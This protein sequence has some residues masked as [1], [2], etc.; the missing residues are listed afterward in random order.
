MSQ[1]NLLTII[2]SQ[3]K[4]LTNVMLRKV[5]ISPES[6]AEVVNQFHRLYHDSHI[7]GKTWGNTSWFGV[8][9]LK[10]PLDLWVYQEII[11]EVRPDIIIEC[12]TASGGS[13]LFL[14]NMCDMVGNGRVITVDIEGKPG[15]PQHP[16]TIYL[17]GSSTSPEIIREIQKL[18]HFGDKVMVV[19]DSDHSRDHVLKELEVYS[20]LVTRGSYLIVEDTNMNGHPVAPDF[21]P[22][23]MEAVAEFLSST[24]DFIV[25][26]GREKFY[27]TFNPGGYLKKIR[28]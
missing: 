22:G 18:L 13:A 6:E 26:R 5:Y 20:T 4:A 17:H 3:A 28:N 7:F 12:G 23:P 16:R 10:C 24:D 1:D 2:K 21:G 11:H 25:D 14:A 9:T 27:L 15:R 8:P 19:L